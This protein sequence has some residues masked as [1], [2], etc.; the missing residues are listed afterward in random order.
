MIRLLGAAIL[1]ASAVS[2]VLAQGSP[3]GAFSCDFYRYLEQHE[4]NVDMM[5]L[6]DRMRRQREEQRQQMEEV[7]R[8]MDEVRRQQSIPSPYPA[9]S[10]IGSMPCDPSR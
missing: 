6:E 5:F 2:A 3:C 4:R 8:G 10:L 9:C 1:I 7:R